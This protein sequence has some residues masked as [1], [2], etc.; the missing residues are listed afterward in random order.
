MIDLLLAK[1]TKEGIAAL[2]ENTWI[3]GERL[4]LDGQVELAAWKQMYEQ[5]KRLVR[6]AAMA[7][8]A[9]YL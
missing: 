2:Q 9:H 3:Y 4:K 7:L 6:T 8:M 1:L 5:K